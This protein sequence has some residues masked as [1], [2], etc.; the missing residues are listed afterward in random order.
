MIPKGVASLVAL[1][2]MGYCHVSV[3]FKGRFGC[4]SM[5][6]LG[7]EGVVVSVWW[8]HLSTLPPGPTFLQPTQPSVCDLFD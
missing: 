2:I 7:V 4:G 3:S 8:V 1:M 5:R 6:W